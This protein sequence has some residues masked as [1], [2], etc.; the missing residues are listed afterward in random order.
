MAAKRRRRGEV[1]DGFFDYELHEL[2]GEPGAG[3]VESADGKIRKAEPER[4]VDG[5]KAKAET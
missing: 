1:K 3:S 5:P 2:S 4:S